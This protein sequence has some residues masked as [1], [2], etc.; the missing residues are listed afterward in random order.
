M[1]RVLAAAT[2]AMLAYASVGAFAFLLAV[3]PTR[4]YRQAPGWVALRERFALRGASNGSGGQ[5]LL[6]GTTAF[7]V[8]HAA[9]WCAA[10]RVPCSQVCCRR[11]CSTLLYPPHTYPSAQLTPS[12]PPPTLER[13]RSCCGS[14]V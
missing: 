4:W 7:M 1:A 11:G 3:T 9:V 12:P 14:W 6:D 2:V 10:C 5:P 8:R 13:T